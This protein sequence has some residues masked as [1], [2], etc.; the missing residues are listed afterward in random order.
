MNP[1]V[2]LQAARLG[3]CLIT[4]LAAIRF[5]LSMDPNVSFQVVRPRECLITIRLSLDPSPVGLGPPL[6]VSRSSYC[7][8]HKI[9]FYAD[10]N[11]TTNHYHYCHPPPT[12]FSVP[13][14]NTGKCFERPAKILSWR[15][16]FGDNLGAGVS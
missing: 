7:D 13:K 12:T 10:A 5:L 3:E 6:L 4:F 9:N 16:R 1:N 15:Q 11:F 14:G 8:A 2:F